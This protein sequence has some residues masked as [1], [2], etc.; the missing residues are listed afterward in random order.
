METLSL[1]MS[2]FLVALEPMNLLACI[3]GVVAG[4]IIGALPGLGP[5]AGC[6][7]ILPLTF[8]VNPTTGII[9]LAGIYYGAM[10]GGA[11]TSILINTPGDSAAVMTCLDGYPMAQKGYPGRAL[12][13]AAWASF[14]G[15]TTCVIIFTFMAPKLAA[16]A[17]WFGP[18]ENFTLMLMGLATVSGLTGKY[19]AKG[20]TSMFLGLVLTVIGVDLMTGLP[21]Y[22]F[23]IMEL[24][25]GIDF[26]V[27]ALGLFGITEVINLAFTE[28]AK[29]RISVKL[30]VKD[31]FPTKEDWK[32]SYPHIVRSTGIG[33]LV[34]MLPGAGATIATFIAYATAKKASKRSELFGTGIPEG[35]AAPESA[36]NAASVGAWVPLL[37]LGI[38]G[39]ATTA[40]FLGALMMHNLR[41]GPLIF[42]EAPR[43]VWGLISSMYVGNVLLML[44]LVFFIPLFIKVLNIPKWS[45]MAWMTAFILA[46]SYSL[47]SSMFDV[48]MTIGFGALGFFLKQL[49]V[50]AAPMILA[51]VLGNLMED[52]LRQSLVLSNGSLSIFFTRP[53]SAALLV[54]ALGSIVL[55]ILKSLYKKRATRA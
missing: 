34:G 27:V 55:P 46:G 50:P 25:S 29:E 51:L 26:V 21:R 18:P 17:L 6:A 44:A 8:G 2:G 54:I 42:Q 11:I 3:V 43:L 49:E 5:S 33:F 1:L 32:Y 31:G 39:S 12:G 30:R 45:L 4:A 15:G 47:N 28:F 20:L 35:I 16:M 14:I 13:M 52:A 24:Y 37:T 10:Y 48:W 38:P 41:P 19:P 9:L 53:L 7:I 23:G 36:N 22:C 40:V